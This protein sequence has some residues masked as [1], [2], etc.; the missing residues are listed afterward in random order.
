MALNRRDEMVLEFNTN[1]SLAHKLLFP[2]RHKETS[3]PFH[4][5]IISLFNSTSTL[6][7]LMA[8]RGGAKSTIIEEDAILKALNKEVEFI[9][10]VG[11]SWSSACERLAPI[12]Q[13]LETNDAL[14]ELYGDQ[15]SSPWAVDEIVLA[16]GVKI[17]ALG[18][19]QSMRGIKHNNARPDYVIIDDLEDE[20]NVAT[21][22]SRRKTERWLASTLRPAL[23]PKT[24]R[25]RFIGTALHPEALI[26]KKCDDPEWVSRK[27][28]VLYNDEDGQEVS[29]WP[30]RFSL[31]WIYKLK[32]EYVSNGNLIEFEQEYMC[33]AEDVTGKPFQPSMIKIAAPP[34]GFLPVEIAIDPARTTK[35]TSAR[36][37][38][39][40]FSWIGGRLIVHEA[41]G[42]FH[43]P[44]EIIKTI[45][46]W[47]AKYN[48]VRIGVEAN[49][50]DE[51]IMQPIRDRALQLN[52]S[53]PIEPL[54]APKDKEGF[55]K[56]LQ[57]FYMSGSV[58]HAKHLPDLEAELLQF[59]TGRKD[60]VNAL[61]YA[62]RM[63]AGRAV[64]EDFS[65]D[66]I[67]PVLEVYPS[68]P[69]WLVMSSR[70]SCCAAVLLQYADGALRVYKDWLV[71]KPAQETFLN[72]LTEAIQ[73][74]GGA[75]KIGAP[76][77]QFDKYTNNGLP[78]AAKRNN[79]SLVRL[80]S[81]SKSEGFI[82]EYMTKRLRGSPALLVCEEAPWVIKG[83]ARGYA[84]KLEKDGMLAPLPEDNEYRLVAETLEV[85]CAWLKQN[86]NFTDNNDG[87][88]YAVTND[89]RKYLTSLPGR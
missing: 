49:S 73:V 67:T 68:S 51:F 34:S 69:K 35:T 77:E 27:F 89:G 37:G 19:R 88:R 57:P 83:L 53:L 28:P 47:N 24:G 8:F 86:Q 87:R 25:I 64:Y 74:A 50:L 11:N 62:L 20:E 82:K 15:K 75:V 54:Y 78:A 30:D 32:N 79:I 71:N 22:E 16:N 72:I 10:I 23:N 26:Q 3:P 44:D 6:V 70:A 85:F 63:R 1:R 58:T 18:A 9:L 5:D 31:E 59:P 41:V 48:P 36:T 43:K 7:A 12:K 45:F 2:H 76:V 39:A 42:H 4:Q 13:E 81:T 65:I 38:Y 61:A 80:G 55:I 14:I 84:R 66:S 29:A 21:A 17:Q 52:V 60:V 46:E 33:R 56:G 40:A